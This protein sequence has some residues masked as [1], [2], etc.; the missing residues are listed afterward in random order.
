MFLA[1][2][3]DGLGL[4]DAA[5]PRTP[6]LRADF[7]GA[8]V[9]RRLQ[10]GRRSALARALGLHRRPVQSVFDA[11]CGLARDSAVL[12]GLGCEVRAAERHPVMRAL[13]EDGLARAM[14][15]SP[16][17]LQG[18]HG[19]VAGD[20]TDWLA[21]RPAPV[22]DVIYLD[23]MFGDAGRRALPKQPMQ[24]LD[25]VVGD[26]EDPER[27]LAV[28]R[29]RAGRRVVAKRHRR[30]PAL[31]PPDLR[32]DTRGARFDIYLCPEPP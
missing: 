12:L 27:L 14:R 16:E 1:L 31:A 5:A 25:T 11:T 22:A 18:W 3:A 30:A 21:A 4:C 6:P 32:I 29:A 15:E 23:P 20:A 24:T 8:D 9:D 10:G 13:I 26:D 17:R 2:D 7:T 28:A 19:L